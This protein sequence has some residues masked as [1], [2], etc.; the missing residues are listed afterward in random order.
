MRRM[1]VEVSRSLLFGVAVGLVALQAM[2]LACQPGCANLGAELK[3]EAEKA[4]AV[5]IDCGS[6]IVD[7]A[8]EEILGSVRDILV[9]GLANWRQALLEK[10]ARVGKEFVA[11]AVE[12]IADSPPRFAA[13]AMSAKGTEVEDEHTRARAFLSEQSWTPTNVH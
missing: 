13:Y 7:H 6:V 11:C 2:T 9:G 5:V 10:A 12:K 4:E 1:I 8:F 3:K